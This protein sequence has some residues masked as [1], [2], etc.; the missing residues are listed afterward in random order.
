MAFQIMKAQ[1][2]ALY[3]R[4]LSSQ[5]VKNIIVRGG[6]YVVGSTPAEFTAFLK[7]DD[8]YQT[9]LMAQLGLNGK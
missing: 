1:F 6:Q 3:K 5:Q 9:R 7:K 8:A 2:Y 4:T